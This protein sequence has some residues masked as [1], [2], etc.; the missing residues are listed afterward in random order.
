[1][2]GS[3]IA[4]LASGGVDSCVLIGVLAGSRAE[5]ADG[6]AGLVRPIYVRC[7]LAWEEVESRQLRAFVG[8][9]GMANVAEPTEL[10]FELADVYG[11]HW[12]T[13]GDDHRHIALCW[14][15][16]SPAFE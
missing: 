11:A 16:Q 2:A 14:L 13:G 10:S 3:G 5:G 9:L 15:F 12:S 7:G 4:V 1:M 8:A 6:A